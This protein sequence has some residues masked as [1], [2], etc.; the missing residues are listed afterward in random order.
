M[1]SCHWIGESNSQQCVILT[2]ML[3]ELGTVSSAGQVLSSL[4]SGGEGVMYR[5][6][7]TIVT[8]QLPTHPPPPTPPQKKN[9]KRR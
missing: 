7:H 1:I 8:E 6:E 5:S 2:S 4:S 3:W 9:K